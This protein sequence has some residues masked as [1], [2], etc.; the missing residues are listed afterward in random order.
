MSIRKPGSA[1]FLALALITT[2]FAGIS[3]AD[4][5]DSSAFEWDWNNET[6]TLTIIPTPFL[7]TTTF[8]YDITI[9]DYDWNDVFYEGYYDIPT[10]N[11][12]VTTNLTDGHYMLSIS[13]FNEYDSWFEY[14]APICMGMNC[15]ETQ[16]EISYDETTMIATLFVTGNASDER[17]TASLYDVWTGNEQVLYD[18]KNGDTI[19]IGGQGDGY[20]CLHLI[21]ETVD[22]FEIDVD[23][24]CTQ[25]GEEPVW[26]SAETTYD[27][28]NMFLI[29]E[30]YDLPDNSTFDYYAT[31]ESW[32]TGFETWDNGTID[33]NTTSIGFDIDEILS[34]NNQEYGLYWAEME[35]MDTEGNFVIDAGTEFCYGN[36][37]DCEEVEEMFLCD[38]GDE[39][40]MNYY[41]DG[42]DDC[43]DGSD[44]PNGTTD[45]IFVCDNGN[46]IP[47]NYYDDYYDDCGDGS[48]EPNLDYE[49]P[50]MICVDAYEML[51]EDLVT[52]E[53][54][55]NDS[56]YNL[57]DDEKYYSC[58]TFS[59]CDDSDDEDEGDDMN[60]TSMDIDIWFE[61]WDDNTM[62]FV[63]IQNVVIDDPDVIAMYA[64][65]ADMYMGNDDGEITQNEVDSLM[66]ELASDTT[67]GDSDSDSDSEMTNIISLDGNAGVV[68]E[69]WME[70][71]GL[72]GITEDNIGDSKISMIF[73]EVISFNTTAY[74]DSTTHI[75]AIYDD[76]DDADDSSEEPVPDEGCDV[77]GI[78][79]HN[80]DTWSV[81][82]ITD[83]AGTLEFTYDDYNN[84][85]FTENCPDDSGTVTFNLVKTDIGELPD[86]NNPSNPIIAW[87]DM[88]MNKFPMCAYAY[89]VIMANGTYDTRVGVVAAPESGD[90]IIDLMDGAEYKIYV[91]CIDPEGEEMYVKIH[92]TD[93]NLTSEYTATGEAEA[94]LLLSVPAGYDGTYVFNVTWTDGHHTESGTLTVN[95]LGDG[96]GGDL[97]A[98]GE[99][100]LPGFTAILGIVALL[101]AAMI[102]GR[103]NRA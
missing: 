3:S 24:I 28:L 25:I 94:S 59:N 61:Q 60:V 43:G 70:I 55:E 32:D 12:S 82:S 90:Y 22:G 13:V 103:R 27:S 15:S 49:E 26:P 10:A 16:V 84:A 21:V 74:A 41:D 76:D 78:W 63:M 91:V 23:E 85:W 45:G 95:G 29:V 9:M 75:F 97:V 80:S 48:D 100:V 51:I 1:I 87:E 56:P 62:E 17:I 66:L 64:M 4:G 33:S 38:N 47:M 42:D 93:L 14:D 54:C 39:I 34:S 50:E 8:D 96:T 19:D 67:D 53:D 86:R 88:D 31:I 37:S 68:V 69:S 57:W 65:F 98:N 40:P 35:I 81:S 58:Q 73:G 52:K 5:D 79:I 102:S 83:A 18:V 72:V 2:T 20:F 30:L 7:N 101:G 77:D 6:G 11:V 92:N 36:Q 99:G 46:E 89:S 71:D 44:E